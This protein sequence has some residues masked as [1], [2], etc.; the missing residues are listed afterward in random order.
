MALS[1]NADKKIK[2]LVKKRG[3]DCSDCRIFSSGDLDTDCN[4]RESWFFV[5]AKELV[6]VNLPRF[7]GIKTFSGYPH[8]ENYAPPSA[9]ELEIE[10]IPNESIKKLFA[11]DLAAGVLLCGEIDGETRR[12]AVFSAGKGADARKLCEGFEI[13]KRNSPFPTNFLRSGKIPSFAKNAG[14]RIPIASAEYVPS[15][16]IHAAF[17]CEQCHILDP[18]KLRWPC[19]S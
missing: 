14:H 9:D 3:I 8:K 13:I 12:L 6:V 4:F 18:I 17:L 19:L 5:F 15:A 16:P 1:K 2:T 7:T 11:V 10:R